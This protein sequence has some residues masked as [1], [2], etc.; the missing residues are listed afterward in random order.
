[1]S[2]RD[3]TEIHNLRAEVKTL[4]ELLRE[5]A[6]SPPVFDD[7]RMGCIEVQIVRPLWRELQ[8]LRVTADGRGQR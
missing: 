2:E 7:E 3:W 4:R 6:D 8:A 5:V 1:M